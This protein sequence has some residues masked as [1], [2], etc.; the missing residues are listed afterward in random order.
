MPKH[1]ASEIAPV[2]AGTSCPHRALKFTG[3]ACAMLALLSFGACSAL[4]KERAPDPNQLPIVLVS[5]TPSSLTFHFRAYSPSGGPPSGLTLWLGDKERTI[6]SPG[7]EYGTAVIESTPEGLI[8]TVNWPAEGVFGKD[9]HLRSGPI[10]LSDFA[11]RP[12]PLV[13]DAFGRVAIADGARP[14]QPK[15]AIYLSISNL[16]AGTK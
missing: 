10:Q 3:L 16:E 9:G 2:A 15:M 12:D 6:A 14:G 5:R 11:F 8:W 13:W 1:A 4:P 7:V